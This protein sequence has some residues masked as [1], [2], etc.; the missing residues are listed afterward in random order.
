MTKDTYKDIV[1]GMMR[2]GLEAT[3]AMASVLKPQN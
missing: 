3:E 2:A 1:V